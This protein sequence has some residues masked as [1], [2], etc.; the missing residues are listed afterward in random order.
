[1]LARTIRK[2]YALCGGKTAFLQKSSRYS[3]AL[4]LRLSGSRRVRNINGKLRSTYETCMDNPTRLAKYAIFQLEY[5]T[6]L[7]RLDPRPQRATL[8]ACLSMTSTICRSSS[9][10]L[11]ILRWGVFDLTGPD[12]RKCRQEAFKTQSSHNSHHHLIIQKMKQE[13]QQGSMLFD[14]DLLFASF[15]IYLITII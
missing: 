8:V 13:N 14:I 6:S 2:N 5:P 1:V 7:Q 9:A 11:R 15:I 10:G 3:G 4:P 12:Y